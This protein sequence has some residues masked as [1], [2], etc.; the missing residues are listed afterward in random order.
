M[1]SYNPIGPKEEHFKVY[2]RLKF[3][4][5]NLEVYS[6]GESDGAAIEEYSQVLFKLY[7]WVQMAME[8]RKAD[9]QRRREYKRKLKEE[10]LMRIEEDKE[11]SRMRA[12]ELEN[13]IAAF[14]AELEAEDEGMEEGEESY[15]PNKKHKEKPKFDEEEF[16]RKWDEE[17]AEI[18]IP[19]EIVDDIDNDYDIEDRNEDG[20]Q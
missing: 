10:R 17:N 2:Q 11:R 7:K 14:E 12:V 4:E 1:E 9:V 3:L 18:V 5:K 8:V 15:S 6:Q 19:D 20:Q 13:A 16:L